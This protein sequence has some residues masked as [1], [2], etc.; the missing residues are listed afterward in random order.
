[1]SRMSPALTGVFFTT[2]TTWEEYTVY[3]MSNISF[4]LTQ[5]SGA[6][7][8]FPPLSPVAYWTPS[9]LGGS[10]SSVMMF[11]P[12]HTFHGVLMARIL[13]QVAMNFRGPCFIK[14]PL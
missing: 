3:F 8:N 2:G 7:S 12:F 1:M 5:L 14:T 6:I 11:L 4:T 13:E 9:H 10:S